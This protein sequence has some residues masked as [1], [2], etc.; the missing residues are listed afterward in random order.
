MYFYLK[1]PC[2]I[3]VIS[4]WTWNSC[5]M[6]LS[7]VPERNMR[8][9]YV[10]P[11]RHITV[12]SCLVTLGSDQ[13]ARFESHFRQQNHQQKAIWEMWELDRKTLVYRW[14]AETRR[15]S[16]T[17]FDTS[18]GNMHDDWFQFVSTLHIS[19]MTVKLLQI[20]IWWL[21]VYF[22]EQTGSK[23]Q[24]PRI[25]KINLTYRLYVRELLFPML[26]KKGLE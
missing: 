22:R 16:V 19:M 14:R 5:Q 4:S 8:N 18:V 1:T 25:M 10:F 9:M 17:S 20:L 23:I 6:A 24:N 26:Y 15:Q 7:R 21:Q 13:S 12:F 2:L 11:L 3:Y